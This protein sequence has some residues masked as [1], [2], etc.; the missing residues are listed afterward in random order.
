MTLS[1]D[2]AHRV[3]Q[4]FPIARK[5]HDC[6]EELPE[7]PDLP[8]VNFNYWNYCWSIRGAAQRMTVAP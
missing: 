3:V 1:S 4:I 5:N 2:S 6:R 8:L 7:L